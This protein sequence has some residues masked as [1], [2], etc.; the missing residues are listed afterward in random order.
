MKQLQQIKYVVLAALLALATS[1]LSGCAT[2][3]SALECGAESMNP[4]VMAALDSFESAAISIKLSNRV[5]LNS[6]LS[7]QDSWPNDLFGAPSGV[8]LFKMGLS[9]FASS[10]GITLAT[11]IDPAT[12]WPRPTSALYIFLKER[13]KLL[14]KHV[15]KQDIAFFKPQPRDVYYREL[16]PRKKPGTTHEYVYR[17][18]LMAYGVVANNKKEMLQLEEEINL[19]ANGYTQCDAFLR[20]ASSTSTE[21]VKKAACKDPALKDETITAALK[22]KTEDMATMEKNY[23]KL[24]NKIYSA[25]V[26]GADF[27]MA[28]T[29]KIAC[30]VVNGI[31]AF[32]NIQNE[33]RRMRGVYN[34]A[35]L[36]PRIKMV[37]G[38]LG[39]YKD[40]LGLQYTVYKTMYQQIKGKYQIK[41]ENPATEQNTREALRRIDLAET[42][43]QQLEPKLM[44]AFAGE[45]VE[46]S[47]QEAKKIE[48]IAAMF[49]AKDTM[50]QLVALEQL[51]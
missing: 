2:G 17:N 23:G 39:I 42:A 29:V 24:A 3:M 18:P 14:N 10:Q 19:T 26:A 48:L 6:P 1:G 41:D 22:E 15:N 44:L 38:S 11:E 50:T 30:A 20:S 35:M 51:K 13:E 40:N 46:F 9:A 21:D 28:S 25:S 12:G 36:F 5:L 7:E 27:T 32:P 33:F 8:A 47:D 49:P 43:L 4:T 16:G 37:F 45:P 34:A 31:R